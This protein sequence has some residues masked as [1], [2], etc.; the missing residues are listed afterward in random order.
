MIL[1]NDKFIKYL[2][3]KHLYGYAMS[4]SLPTSEYMWL[5]SAKL[6]LDKN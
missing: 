5:D 4:K 6:S 2:D 1:K 3:K